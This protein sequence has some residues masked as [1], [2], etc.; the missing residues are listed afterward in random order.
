MSKEAW[1]VRQFYDAE[2]DYLYELNDQRGSFETK[3][4]AYS[5]G[6]SYY[7]TYSSAIYSYELW[8]SNSGKTYKV[9]E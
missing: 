4:E 7:G 8:E 2:P 6:L 9:G 1:F 5:F 3:E